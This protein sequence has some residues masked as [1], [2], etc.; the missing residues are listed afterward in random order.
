MSFSDNK[1]FQSRVNHSPTTLIS[2]MCLSR[3]KR[4]GDASCPDLFVTRKMEERRRRR[5][6]SDEWRPLPIQ[7]TFLMAEAKRKRQ[8]SNQKVLWYRL[9]HPDERVWYG[10]VFW[11]L[12]KCGRNDYMKMQHSCMPIKRGECYLIQLL[13]NEVCSKH[14]AL[15][16][17]FTRN[18]W[19]KVSFHGRS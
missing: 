2:C 9:S 4:G 19:L 1:C 6:R 5:R 14:A 10:R 18:F 11:I 8:D 15:N 7:S 12:V 16:Q 3:K 13:E 17:A